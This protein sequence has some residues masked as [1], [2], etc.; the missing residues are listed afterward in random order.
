MSNTTSS[1][2]SR[3]IIVLV[4]IILLGCLGV[5]CLAGVGYALLGPGIPGLTDSTEA[6]TT[7]TRLAASVTPTSEGEPSPA[8]NTASPVAP[9]TLAIVTTAPDDV[10][11]ITVTATPQ[12]LTEPTLFPTDTP[13]PTIS[14]GG[15][16]LAPRLANHTNCQT[17][18]SQFSRDSIIEFNWTWSQRVNSD[19]GFYLEVRIGP[20]GATNLASMGAINNDA[21]LDPAQNLWQAR[22]SVSQ[23]YQTTANDYEW[24]VAYMNNSQRVVVASGRGCFDIR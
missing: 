22:I 13:A 23:F 6:T 5:L 12:L 2:G 24:Q 21:L 10:P 9:S 17:S 11:Q 8:S 15:G 7:P 19:G 1:G 18:I 20:R 4:I 14:G 3:Q 16:P